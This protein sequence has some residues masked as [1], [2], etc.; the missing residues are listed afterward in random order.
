MNLTQL[1]Y[2]VEA[3]KARSFTKAAETLCVTQQGVSKGVANLESELHAALFERG[4]AGLTL[5]EAGKRVFGRARV[6]LRNAELLTEDAT[7]GQGSPEAASVIRLGM[8]S[9]ILGERYTLRLDDVLSFEK[10]HVN[11]RLKVIEASS[12][13][14]QEMLEA[15][16]LDVAVVAGRADWRRFVTKRLSERAFVPFVGRTHR[17]A[18]A[19]D[20][21]MAELSGET[22]LIPRGSTASIN[23]ICESFYDAGVL[24]PSPD[25][26]VTHDC[27]PQLMMD[28]VYRGEGVAFMRDNN[29]GCIDE[30]RGVVLDMPS[31]AFAS[32]LSVAIRRQ[33]AHD[34]VIWELIDY[35]CRLLRTETD[36]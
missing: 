7:S 14:C 17:L 4:P 3:A 11:L 36:S 31:A 6:I 16:E 1:E 22:F 29:L 30:R 5:T 33:L 18:E 27:T 15:G 28:H 32:R 21:S 34:S 26:F 25:Q 8:C 13:L 12:D 20:V 35:L 19:R 24:V 2:F 10:R 23:E 9:V